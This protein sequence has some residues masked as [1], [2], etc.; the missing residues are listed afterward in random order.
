MAVQSLSSKA[1]FVVQSTAKLNQQ[2]GAKRVPSTTLTVN[3]TRY[4]LRGKPSL[5]KLKICGS[6]QELLQSLKYSIFVVIYWGRHYKLLT[7]PLLPSTA[8]SLLPGPSFPRAQRTQRFSSLPIGFS[9]PTVHSS[10]SSPSLLRGLGLRFSCSQPL[11][12]PTPDTRHVEI[13]RLMI[14]RSRS[15]A[16]RKSKQLHFDFR[17][18]SRRYPSIAI[19]P[20]ASSRLMRPISCPSTPET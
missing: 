19:S 9:I 6:Y 15:F 12:I 1:K 10:L 17:G 3:H 18:L 7:Q 20:L 11:G 2:M 13:P 8:Q 16:S 14:S 4:T 5:H